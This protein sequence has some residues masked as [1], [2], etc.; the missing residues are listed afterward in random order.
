MVRSFQEYVEPG[1]EFPAS[2]QRRNTASP[3][4]RD[5]SVILPL[6]EDTLTHNLGIPVVVV[7]T[8]VSSWDGILV[9]SIFT[10]SSHSL[11]PDALVKNDDPVDTTQDSRSAGSISVSLHSFYVVTF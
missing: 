3:D 1:E 6:G 2:P 11:F 4:D 9:S 5:E 7:C 8:K 10:Y